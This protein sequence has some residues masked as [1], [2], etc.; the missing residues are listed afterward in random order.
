MEN[1]VKA[2]RLKSAPI[3]F[4]ECSKNQDNLEQVMDFC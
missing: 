3:I 2:G 1:K 4:C